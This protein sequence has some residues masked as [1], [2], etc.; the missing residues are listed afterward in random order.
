MPY[1][2]SSLLPRSGGSEACISIEML[3]AAHGDCL[4]IEYGTGSR[5]A[6]VLVDCGT[7]SC[8]K[9]VLRGR[10]Q[11]LAAGERHVELFILSHI[12]AD[13]IG[14]ALPL[15][16][17]AKALGVTFG[18]IWFNAWRHLSGYLGAEQGEEFSALIQQNGFSW[19]AWKAGEAIVL[20]GETLPACTLPG[21]MVMTLLSPSRDKLAALAPKW[22]KEIE[23]LNRTPGKADDFL[24][25][26]VSSSKDVIALADAKFTPDAAANNGSS[27]AVLLEYQGKRVLLGADAHAPLL[28]ASIKKLLARRGAQK[29]A[30]DAFKLPHHGSQNNLNIE[31]MQLLDCR[32]YLVS[33][34]GSHFNHPDREAI[35]RAIHYG[36][37]RPALYFNYESRLN[38]VWKE[39][40]LQQKYGYE[41]IFPPEGTQGLTVRL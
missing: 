41:A 25:A 11:S 8:Y 30:L 32:K 33:T 23:A 10:I 4:W 27:I 22:K 5:T 1:E 12:D 39:A 28:V 26:V 38:S 3:P 17:E 15:L 16:A 24:G 13:H 19:N 29:L 34:N 2:T 21:G 37:E 36:G 40:A 7:A 9:N 31:L 18:D 6:R 20:G 35:G 14:G